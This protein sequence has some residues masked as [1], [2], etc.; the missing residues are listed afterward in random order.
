M[1]VWRSND[2]ADR[3]SR[4]KCAIH[5]ASSGSI[6]SIPREA[7]LNRIY[8]QLG[9]TEAGQRVDRSAFSIDKILAKAQ[10]IMAPYSLEAPVVDWWTV[11]EI[12]QRLA[13]SMSAFQDRCFIAGDAAHLHS[14]KAG[15]G[16]NIVRGPSE[17]AI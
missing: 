10:Q 15:Q 16:M 7:G 5:S 1:F 3:R 4:L 17:A 6:L 8:V 11:Y 2:C 12:G 9:T 14:P 13:T